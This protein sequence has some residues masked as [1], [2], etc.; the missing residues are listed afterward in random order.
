[1]FFVNS[2]TVHETNW[3]GSKNFRAVGKS[4][5][6]QRTITKS[7][8]MVSPQSMQSTVDCFLRSEPVIRGSKGEPRAKGK[9]KAGTVGA[10][11]LAESCFEATVARFAHVGFDSP[12][13][14]W[15]SIPDL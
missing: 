13:G 2:H 8:P 3:N 12:K 7:T 14:Y 9:K 1:M 10:E 6:Y 11:P 5:V 15:Q 4:A